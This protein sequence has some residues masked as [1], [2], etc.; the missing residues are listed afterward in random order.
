VFHF[1]LFKFS[2]FYSLLFVVSLVGFCFCF[3][4]P[5]VCAMLTT[6]TTTTTRHVCVALAATLLLA[7]ISVQGMNFILKEGKEKC[8]IEDGM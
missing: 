1:L 5:Q 7:T 6:M 3:F 2:L 8:F 4:S